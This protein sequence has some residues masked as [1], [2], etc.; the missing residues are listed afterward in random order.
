MSPVYFSELPPSVL[1]KTPRHLQQGGEYSKQKKP[2][3]HSRLERN[4]KMFDDIIELVARERQRKIKARFYEIPELEKKARERQRK[5]TITII[6]KP[7]VVA[8]NTGQEQE[9]EK[10]ATIK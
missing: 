10:A 5:I 4:L 7:R 8:T 2:A 6:E 9:Q 3:I 1:E